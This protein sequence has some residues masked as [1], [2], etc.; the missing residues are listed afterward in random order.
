LHCSIK[1]WT[2]YCGSFEYSNHKEKPGTYT[3][4]YGLCTVQYVMD[5]FNVIYFYICI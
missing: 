2:G 3:V 4:E 1:L 5:E